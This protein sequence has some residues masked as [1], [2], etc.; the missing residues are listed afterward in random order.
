MCDT[1]CVVSNG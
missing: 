1:V